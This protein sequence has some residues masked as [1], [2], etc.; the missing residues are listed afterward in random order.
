M[1][2][3]IIIFVCSFFMLCVV[4]SASFNNTLISP[5]AGSWYPAN[6]DVL[7][8]MLSGML[9]KVAVEK[10]DDV[11]A[12]IL[13]HAGYKYSGKVASYGVKEVMNRT[14]SRVIILGTSHSYRLKNKI[15][16]PSFQ[17]YVTP[18]G[19]VNV[20]R[21]FINRLI[22]VMPYGVM[23]DV[24]H[25]KEHSIQIQLPLLQKALKNFKFVPIIVGQLDQVKAKEIGEILRGCIDD[26][27]LVIASSDFTHYGPNFDYAPFKNNFQVED[28][29]KKLDTGA[30]RYIEQK[31]PVALNQYL[32][33]TGATVCGSNPI[34][35][36]LYML[37]G[38]AKVKLLKYDTS[39]SQMKDFTNSVSYASFAVTG[40][41]NCPKPIEKNDKEFLTQ[42]EKNNLLI[43]ARKSIEYYLQKKT[44]P[45]IK[46][47]NVK[48]SD[49][50]KNIMGGFV[51]LYKNG[52]L[53]GCIGEILPTRPI[54]QV[55]I[56]Q[57][58]NAAVNDYRFPP[59]KIDEINEI[60]IEISAL[61]PPK[62]VDS[63]KDI[64][65]GRDGMTIS[66]KGHRA[67]FLPQVAP[68]QGWN[69][70]TTLKYLSIKAG[71]PTDGWKSGA[72]F[73]VFQAIVFDDRLF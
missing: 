54:Y 37:P 55:V 53:R 14:F 73:T 17:S 18:F 11:I 51:S 31:N 69:I 3:K 6:A 40:S 67:V 71:L 64:V 36:L 5:L 34:S 26:K 38:N 10:N 46:D 45:T 43:I 33:Q 2:N 16:V 24:A 32:E 65:I 12:L 28:N 52:Q 70:E 27:T 39:G 62:K 35:V 20:D 66:K 60:K 58:V 13:P 56:I 42:E 57:A 23:H 68:K 44:I 29:L 19:K 72:V 21:D 7:N 25:M 61:T 4:C 15:S 49:N 22:P 41:W 30:F 1:K 47:L 8:K 48:V 59:V 63:Y 50:M 9:D